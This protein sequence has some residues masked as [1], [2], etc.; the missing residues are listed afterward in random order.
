MPKK[1]LTFEQAMDRLEEIV[2]LLESGDS[3]LD[4]SLSLFEEGVKLVKLCNSQLEKAESS[5][6]QLINQDGEIIEKEFDI[7]ENK[8]D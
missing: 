8:N 7:G 6:K 3:P 5:V 2:S 1:D 4:K